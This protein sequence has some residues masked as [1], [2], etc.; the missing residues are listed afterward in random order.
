MNSSLIDHF[1]TLL[2]GTF[3]KEYKLIRTGNCKQ[4][5]QVCF[6]WFLDK[7]EH[8]NNINC[9]A[10][11][12]MMKAPWNP[13]DGFETLMAQLTK[14]LILAQHMGA[15][16][17]DV[18]VIDMRIG[19]ILITGLFAEEYQQRHCQTLTKKTFAHFKRFWAEQVH[20][21][22]FTMITAGQMGFGMNAQEEE[23]D[24]EYDNAGRI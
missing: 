2:H 14:G 6:Q 19:D 17:S 16:I 12:E 18:D 24:E 8:N 15:A 10:N 7:Y 13:V 3:T 20:I 4:S 1:L 22:K 5:F 21:I 9:M 23:V 11:K